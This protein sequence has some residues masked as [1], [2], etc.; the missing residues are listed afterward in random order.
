MT[1]AAIGV[2]RISSGLGSKKELPLFNAEGNT[3][4]KKRIQRGAG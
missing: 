3:D 2:R 4:V 1:I